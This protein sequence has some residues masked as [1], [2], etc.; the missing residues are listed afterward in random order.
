MKSQLDHFLLKGFQLDPGVAGG[1]GDLDGSF[2]RFVPMRS[3]Y[4]YPFSNKYV[5]GIFPLEAG[6]I[7]LSPPL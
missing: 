2:I 1:V 4:H 6:K 3:Y 7:V 5:I